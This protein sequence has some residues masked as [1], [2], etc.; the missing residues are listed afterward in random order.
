MTPCVSRNGKRDIDN[1]VL[2]SSYCV[3]YPGRF[4]GQCYI[5]RA[6]TSANAAS[7]VRSLGGVG[8]SPLPRAAPSAPLPPALLA[9]IQ[10]ESRAHA[11]ATS[12]A[13]AEAEAHRQLHDE[14]DAEHARVQTDI[15]RY[16]STSSP[17]VLSQH[18][19]SCIEDISHQEG[20]LAKSRRGFQVISRQRPEG[21]AA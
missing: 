11:L 12:S 15:R 5:S 14:L 10:R 19:T 6:P 7:L 18:C 8:Q 20:R 1:K 9:N 4:S 2:T 17:G 16:S 13:N 3:K 21:A